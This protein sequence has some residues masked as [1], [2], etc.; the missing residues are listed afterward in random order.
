MGGGAISNFSQKIGL[1]TTKLVRF[2]ILHKPMG[3]ARAPPRPPPWLRYWTQCGSDL[4]KKSSSKNFCGRSPTKRFS[5]KFLG[6]LKK[7]VFTRLLAFSNKYFNASK[8]SAVLGRGQGNFRGLE[9][10]RPRPSISKYVLE[11]STSG[12]L[13]SL[14]VFRITPCGGPKVMVQDWLPSVLAGLNGKQMSKSQFSW[15][16]ACSFRKNKHFKTLV[17]QTS[18]VETTVL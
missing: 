9:A 2:F 4:K 17:G 1:K 13:I 3:G 18:A 7:K 10:S 8:T 12:V 6:D 11:D 14:I 5:K 15:L 16:L